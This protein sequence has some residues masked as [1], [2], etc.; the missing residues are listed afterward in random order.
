MAGRTIQI[1]LCV[2]MAFDSLVRPVFC[3]VPVVDLAPIDAWLS[4]NADE[5]LRKLIDFVS[6][7]S[8][9]A[10]PS[11]AHEV[12]RA[13]NW[14]W[15]DLKAA[16]LENVQLLE[17]AGHPAVYADWLHADDPEAPTILVYGHFDVQPEDPV[18]LW[19]S[20]PFTPT[21]RDG[22]LYARG[23][24]DDKG[25]MYVPVAAIWA[26]LHTTGTLPVNVKVLFEGEEEV[27]SPHLRALLAEHKELLHA[28][29]AF[30]AD[31]G[32]VSPEIP[33]LCLGLRGAMSMQVSVKVADVDMH[34]GTYG[35]GVQ[36]PIHALARLL[37]SLRDVHT[38]RL[39]VDGFYDEVEELSEEERADIRDYPMQAEEALRMVGAN[40][41]VGEEGFSFFE[42]Y[43]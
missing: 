33:G 14:L 29:F 17:T 21:V 3:S 13:A 30:S 5:N 18:D 8:V 26:Y 41:T 31:G 34:S 25:H 40:E 23:A 24:S 4:A 20:P 6:I 9:S 43:V 16:G 28:D 35:G 15:A 39:L 2:L 32:Q 7:P 37:D 22:K 12:R 11:R 36:N 19:T 42:R 38:G 27:G 10:D 1:L